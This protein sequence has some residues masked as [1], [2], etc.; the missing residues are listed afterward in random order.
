MNKIPA[1][2]IN[3]TVYV[4]TTNGKTISI[5]CDRQQKAAKILETAERGTSIP[6]SIT[7]LAN[8]GKML[9]DKKTIKENNIEAKATIEMF[10][11]FLGGIAKTG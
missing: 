1:G 5:E 11:R 6:R 7:Y 3:K 2:Y 4:K 10:L 8:Q 9:N